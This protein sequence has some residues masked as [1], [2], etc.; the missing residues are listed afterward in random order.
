MR[1]IVVILVVTFLT[2]LLISFVPGS[3][4]EILAPVST[5]QQRA[6]IRREVGLNDNLFVRYGRW[7]ADFSHGDMGKHYSGGATYVSVGGEIK[8]AVPVSLELIAWAQLIA[9]G[10]AVPLGIL[11]ASKA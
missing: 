1:L 2:Q 9:L 3:L 4:D 6:H 7:L 10:L 5:A 8:R 11:A